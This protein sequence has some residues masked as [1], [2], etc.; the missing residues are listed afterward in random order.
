MNNQNNIQDELRGLNSNLPAYNS[1]QNPFSVPEGY[2]DGLAAFVLAKIKGQNTSVADELK[3][4]SPFLAN[5]SRECLIP[6]LPVIL[7]K[8]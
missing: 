1:Q 8:T 4:I 2:F 3:D 6:Y 7:S 5:L